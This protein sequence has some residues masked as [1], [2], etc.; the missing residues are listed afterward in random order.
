MKSFIF[1]FLCVA[2]VIVLLFRAFRAYFLRDPRRTAPPGR[3]I[4]A[5]AD[6]K[7]MAVVEVADRINRTKG[8]GRIETFCEDVHGACTLIAIFM[9]PLSVHYQRVPLSGE[10]LSVRHSPGRFKP[11][12]HLEHGLINEKTETLI[13]T[14]IGRIKVVQIAGI[15]VRRIDNFLHPGLKVRTCDKLGL[16]HF[17]SQVWAILPRKDGIQVTVAAGDKVFAGQSVIATY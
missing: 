1:I 13:E 11:S 14:E 6:G 15:F 12:Q 10:T 17:G 2:V 3:V 4:V 8:L 5:P 16:I 7:I 9:S